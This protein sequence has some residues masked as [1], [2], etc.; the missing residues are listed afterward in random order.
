MTA[1]DV[2]FV[3]LAVA[4]GL[5]A[6]MVVT[7]RNMVHAVLFLAV[8]FGAMAG[9]FLVLHADFVALVQLLIYVGAVAVLLMFGLMLT[10]APIGRE[11]LDSQSRGLGLAVSIALFGVL[12]ALIVRAY[13][14]VRVALAGPD[15]AAIGG[16]IFSQWVLPFELLSLLLTAA[17]VGAIV[18]SRREAGETGEE[19]LADLREARPTIMGG[20]EG[21]AEA[22]RARH[23][24]A[25]GD[26]RET[27]GAGR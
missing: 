6:L 12:A 26:E 24:R 4:G 5:S 16:S 23:L 9:M 17:L 11:A 25:P 2:V 22:R 3:L 13:G 20:P 10:R 7:V 8:T 19:D 1:H 15:V 21:V 27:A 14:D 18:L